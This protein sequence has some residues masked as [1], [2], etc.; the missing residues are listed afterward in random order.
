MGN[1]ACADA[2]RKPACLHASC[3]RAAM[4]TSIVCSVTG[5]V[6]LGQSLSQAPTAQI[7]STPSI[8]VGLGTSFE[9]TLRDA[10]DRALAENLDLRAERYNIDTGDL[11]V[12]GARGAYDPQAGFSVGRSSSSTPTTSILQGGGIVTQE[13]S[14]QTFGP[15]ISQ[16][17]P[18]GGSVNASFPTTRAS[19][20]DAFS[21]VDP[22]FSSDLAIRF[23]QPLLRGLVN[24]PVRHELRDLSFDSKITET[25]F[26]QAVAV[27]VQRVEEQ[28]WAWCTPMPCARF[29]RTRAT[30]R[31][32]SG[33]RSVRK[34]RQA[35]W[36][37]ER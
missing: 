30:S 9:L 12:A 17:L 32:N 33:I 27:I 3:V 24:N 37:P 7:K 6:V 1:T 11:R 22:L 21:F 31:P 29:E 25:Q 23:Q 4:M 14:A 20:N 28:Y 8:V 19:T 5:G 35:C 16:L 2:S 15:T 26:R 13:A 36:R 34:W 18:S 10:I